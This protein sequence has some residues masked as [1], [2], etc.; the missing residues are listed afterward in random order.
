MTDALH[1]IHRIE[2][3]LCE[4]DIDPKESKATSSIPGVKFTNASFSHQYANSIAYL[5]NL[6]IDLKPVSTNTCPVTRS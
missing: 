1:A 5:N 2:H 4:P 3:Y 6:N